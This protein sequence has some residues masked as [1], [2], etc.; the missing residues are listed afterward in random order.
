MHTFVTTAC[1][2]HGHREITLQTEQPPLIPNLERLLLDYFEGAVAAGEKFLPGQIVRVGWAVLRISDRSDGTLGVDE[3]LIASGP[4]TWRGTVDNALA[5]S[6][7]QGEVARSIGLVER[8]AFPMQDQ[9]FVVHECAATSVALELERAANEGLPPA[10]SG[11]RLRCAADHDHGPA[12]AAPLLAIAAKHPALVPF[13][14]LPHGTRVVVTFRPLPD[15]NVRFSPRIYDAS[16]EL[17]PIA[18][19]YV[20]AMQA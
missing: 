3:R 11:W 9:L 20:A 1:A 4:P 10:A 17:V 7:L 15:G 5:D 18:G 6:W 16:G 8:L 12:S 19:S 13:L 14:A 2:R